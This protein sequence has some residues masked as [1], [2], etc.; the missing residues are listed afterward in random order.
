MADYPVVVGTETLAL[1]LLVGA[2]GLSFVSFGLFAGWHALV[3]LVRWYSHRFV[4]VTPPASVRPGALVKVRGRAT[5]PTR[6]DTGGQEGPTEAPFSGRSALYAQWRVWMEEY[7]D[8][9]HTVRSGEVGDAFDV[10]GDAGRVRV[11]TD[12]PPSVEAYGAGGLSHTVDAGDDPPTRVARAADELDLTLPET[13]EV[14]PLTTQGSSLRFEED[15]VRP[16][17]TVQVVGRAVDG[18][19]GVTLTRGRPWDDFHVTDDPAADRETHGLARVALAGGTG[20]VFGGMGLLPL[21]VPLAPFLSASGPAV[22]GAVVVALALLAV[23]G[24]WAIRQVVRTARGRSR[25][26]AG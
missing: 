12:P 8:A 17:E 5:A 1:A 14:G 22:S 15:A 18:D 10:V 26:G 3:L 20:V 7:D 11:G 2:V 16:G 21:S 19:G 25:Y 6:S 13:K 4:D 23:A 9:D 24:A